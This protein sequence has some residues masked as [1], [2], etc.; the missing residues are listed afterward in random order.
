MG[1]RKNSMLTVYNTKDIDYHKIIEQN[2]MRK[3]IKKK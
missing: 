2:G 3:E 1:I